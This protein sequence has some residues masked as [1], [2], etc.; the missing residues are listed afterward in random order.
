MVR[1]VLAVLAVVSIA[2]GVVGST[3][4]TVA[5]VAVAASADTSA[6]FALPYAGDEEAERLLRLQ[7]DRAARTDAHL[8]ARVQVETKTR[9]GTSTTGGGAT[10]DVNDSGGS[11]TRPAGTA[12]APPAGKAGTVVKYARAQVGKAYRFATA[13][14]NTFDC[15]G[16]VVAAYRQIGIS[17]PHQ[18][19]AL[20]GRGRAVS[21]ANLQPGDLVFPHSGHVAIYV[22][23]GMI[24]HASNSK[25]YPQGGVKLSTIYQF[26]YAR[27]IL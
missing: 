20:S 7:I 13:G 1:R 2:F 10:V 23:G 8:Q 14:P 17:L 16:L 24:V 21:R 5:D 4:S 9:S 27:R 22:G 15:S 25:P 11:T 12:P 6:D 3:T 19:G 18:T 26:S